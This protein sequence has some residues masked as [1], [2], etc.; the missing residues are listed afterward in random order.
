MSRWLAIVNPAA[1]RPR[2]TRSLAA[3]LVATSGGRVELVSTRAPGDGARLAAAAGAFDGIVAVGGDGT[4][5]E[6]LNGMDR[7]R[8]LL[9]ILPAG[10]GN[11]L[12]RD[13]GIGA[14]A[15]ALAALAG[16]ASRPVDL[17]AVEI[18]R[19]DGRCERRLCAST[20]AVGFVA[21]VVALGRGPL[22]ALGRHA[23][24]VAA[25]VTRPRPRTFGI[26]VAGPAA[27]RRLT[28]VVVNNTAHLAN[29]RAFRRARLDD[30]MLDLMTADFGWGRQL[31]HSVAVLSGSRR[32]GAT[33]SQASVVALRMPAPQRLMIDGEFADE[34]VAVRA[35]CVPAAL[36]CK[37][38]SR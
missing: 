29:F 11:C 6:V 21:D 24:A 20:L 2:A 8:Q 4:I 5:G 19:A 10:H 38:A 16:P 3:R 23:Y 25:L 36:R 30:G 17:M 7:Q 12:A 28:N 34:V 13:L 15:R 9:G 27:T 33:L 32:F 31:V 18:E 14:P 26:A 37:V 35:T 1:G 22:A